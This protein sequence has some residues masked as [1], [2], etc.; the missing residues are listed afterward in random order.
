[1]GLIAL[2]AAGALAYLWFTKQLTQR[3]LYA[4]VLGVIAVELRR[5]GRI[6]AA[7]AS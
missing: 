2:L 7:C 3:L 1:M 6:G 5:T 4:G